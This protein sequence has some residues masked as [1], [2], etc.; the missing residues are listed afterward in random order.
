MANVWQQ[1]AMVQLQILTTQLA[2]ACADGCDIETRY[3]HLS[4]I[5]VEEGDEVVPGQVIGRVGSTGTSTSDHLHYEMR[6]NGQIVD[7]VIGTLLLDLQF[8]I[9]DASYNIGSGVN[10]HRVH[11][12]IL[13]SVVHQGAPFG[14]SGLPVIRAHNG[15]DIGAARGTAVRAAWHGQ[16]RRARWQGGYGN[17]VYITHRY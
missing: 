17:V 4:S 10:P 13:A 16:V 9:V 15:V 1:A 2:Q 5:E 8:P 6:I 14:S 12:S 7:P 11:P 3:A